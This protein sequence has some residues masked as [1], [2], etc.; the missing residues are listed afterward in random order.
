MGPHPLKS[1]V[2]QRA[3]PFPRPC[4]RVVG[5]PG[6]TNLCETSP[7]PRGGKQ[8]RGR[9][10]PSCEQETKSKG[11]PWA[12]LKRL[13]LGEEIASHDKRGVLQSV[14]PM[15]EAPRLKDKARLD[16]STPRAQSSWVRRLLGKRTGPLPRSGRSQRPIQMYPSSSA[17]SVPV[18][19]KGTEVYL[20]APTSCNTTILR[21]LRT[22]PVTMF[23]CWRR[24]PKWKM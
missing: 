7:N 1:Q 13:F 4:D 6:T 3:K 11:L 14:H 20:L 16:L 19:K 2:W 8:H 15:E 18:G 17:V 24:F 12:D 22:F 10:L 23:S 5:R 9:D 21:M